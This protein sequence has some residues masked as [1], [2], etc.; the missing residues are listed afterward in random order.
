MG[1]ACAAASTEISLSE[2]GDETLASLDSLANSME[3]P[4]WSGNAHVAAL[5]NTLTALTLAHNPIT[6]PTF[7]E[8]SKA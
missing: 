5:T 1:A 6:N 8:W 2:S 4:S 3:A 7:D